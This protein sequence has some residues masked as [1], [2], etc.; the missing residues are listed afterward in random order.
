MAKVHGI[1]GDRA[2][3]VTDIYH[4]PRAA[5]AEIWQ[6]FDADPAK[7]APLGKGWHINGNQAVHVAT[8]GYELPVLEAFADGIGFFRVAGGIRA[9]DLRLQKEK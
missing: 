6:M 5:N 7:L 3:V 9:Y 4:R 2:I 1:G 8:G